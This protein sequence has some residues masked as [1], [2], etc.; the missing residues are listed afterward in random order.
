MHVGVKLEDVSVLLQADD[1]YMQLKKD[2][3][4]LDL[5]VSLQFVLPVS[6]LSRCCWT[7]ELTEMFS[8]TK[9]QTAADF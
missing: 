3:E 8:H 4:Y 6:P 7:V 9:N 1:T 2:L 5:K